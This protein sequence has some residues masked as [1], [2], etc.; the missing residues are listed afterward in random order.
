MDSNVE[1]L[2]GKV[3]A[4]IVY[5]I[6]RE[7]LSESWKE[8]EK[9]DQYHLLKQIDAIPTKL[10]GNRHYFDMDNYDPGCCNSCWLTLECKNYQC[11]VCENYLC[12]DCNEKI[13]SICEKCM[14]KNGEPCDSCH[15]FKHK[16]DMFHT[17][18][19][20]Y[21]CVN[22]IN[23][24]RSQIECLENCLDEMYED[25]LC[26]WCVDTYFECWSCEKYFYLDE[27][28]EYDLCNWCVSD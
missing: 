7:R 11:K 18:C 23:I 16:I 14:E 25:D 15:I 20:R 19:D 22:C 3:Q 17:S 26:N 5:E 24:R 21:Y 6:T 27:M 4:E 13:S 1:S 9:E 28:Y 12:Y 2:S 8:M 10:V